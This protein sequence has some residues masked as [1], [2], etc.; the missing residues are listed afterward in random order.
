[1]LI[2]TDPLPSIGYLVLGVVVLSFFL[3]TVLG[4][5]WVQDI[6]DQTASPRPVAPEPRSAEIGDSPVAEPLSPQ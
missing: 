3:M 1:M 2:E 4:M 5:R 6:S